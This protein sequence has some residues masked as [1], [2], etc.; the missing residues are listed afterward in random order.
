MAEIVRRE[1]IRLARRAFVD[2]LSALEHGH[3]SA[4][5]FAVIGVVHLSDLPEQLE[6]LQRVVALETDRRACIADAAGEGVPHA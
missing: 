6:T 5:A 2:A 3:E 1:R 4:L